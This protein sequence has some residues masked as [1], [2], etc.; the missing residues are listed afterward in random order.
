[1]GNANRYI[2]SGRIGNNNGHNNQDSVRPVVPVLGSRVRRAIPAAR[3]RRVLQEHEHV[4]VDVRLLGGHI[5]AAVGR[6]AALQHQAV[7]SLP[8]LR[9]REPDSALSLPH[10]E[11]ARELRTHHRRLAPRQ[12]LVR[13]QLHPQGVG[14]FPLRYQHTYRVVGP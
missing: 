3:H 9:R 8:A 13:E 1:M 5:L 12:V 14:H 2:R 11:H 4:R 7:H 10:H 6:R